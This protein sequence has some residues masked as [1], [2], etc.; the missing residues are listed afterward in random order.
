MLCRGYFMIGVTIAAWNCWRTA[1]ILFQM[2]ERW[3]LWSKFFQFI[4]RFPLLQG[5]N[6]Y[7]ICFW[8]LKNREERSGSNM[9]LIHWH[10]DL[11]LWVLLFRAIS[12]IHMWWSS[13]RRVWNPYQLWCRLNTSLVGADSLN[14]LPNHWDL[15][16][17]FWRYYLNMWCLWLIL[18]EWN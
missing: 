6:P 2:M 18:W 15:R 9:N 7:L 16:I 5:A 4:Q 17:C 14:V 3:L 13:T 12:V 8:W 1:T 10:L 11:V